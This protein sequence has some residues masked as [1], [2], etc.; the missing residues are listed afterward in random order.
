MSD[1]RPVQ[2][3]L[4]PGFDEPAG[5][6]KGYVPAD[7]ADETTPPSQSSPDAWIVTLKDGR[8]ALAPADA[9]EILA[10]TLGA[11][12]DERPIPHLLADGDAIEFLRLTDYGGAIL[13][14]EEGGGWR[15]SRDMPAGATQ[16][17]ADN[18]PDAIADSV[19]TLVDLLEP[20][21][22]HS[23]R[24]DLSYYDWSGEIAYRFDAADKRFVLVEGN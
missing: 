20:D 24:Y 23:Y 18:D 7:Y 17:C 16:V 10:D 6:I 15:V 21:P 14:V 5:S 9:L 4:L 11:K 3:G 2:L 1:D 12:G 19:E 8:F 22:A 13:N